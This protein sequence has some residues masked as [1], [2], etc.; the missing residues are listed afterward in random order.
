MKR[1]VYTRVFQRQPDMQLMFYHS[2]SPTVR[3]QAYSVCLDLSLRC[4]SL[5]RCPSLSP[6]QA[7]YI[8]L[9]ILSVLRVLMKSGGQGGTDTLLIIFRLICI[10]L[11]FNLIVMYI[12]LGMFLPG[13]HLVSIELWLVQ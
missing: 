12:T 2:V 7:H 1:S 13:L 6:H 9:G 3:S 10:N 5:T 4:S 11:C 8:M